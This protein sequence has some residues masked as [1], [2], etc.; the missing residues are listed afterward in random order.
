VRNQGIREPAAP[1]IFLPWSGAERGAPLILVRTTSDATQSI[2]AIRSE[3]ARIDRQVVA[4]QPTT[5]WEV[6]DRSYYAQPR[7]SLLLLAIFGGT[8][9]ALVA[10]GIFSVMAYTVSRQKKEI[11][12]RMALG[13]SRAHISGIVLRLG[14]RLLAVGGGIGLLASLAAGRVLA[15]QLWNV[16]PRDPLTLIATAIVVTLVA[17]AACYL[18]ARRAMRVE[19]LGALRED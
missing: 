18:P 14:G 8:G 19:P 11:A 3:I 17:L 7:F 13:A 16:S 2:N 1:Q 6:L 5:I 12:L 15:N 4:Q 10:I 9:T